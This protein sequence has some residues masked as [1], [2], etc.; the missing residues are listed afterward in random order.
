M[1]Y[2]LASFL[3]IYAAVMDGDL[4]SW[5]I[6]GPPDTSVLSAVGLL[7]APQGISG[8]HNKYEGDVS[9]GRGDLYE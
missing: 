4:V 2:D 3:S 6:G 5:S 1:G 9:P 7:S 8:S